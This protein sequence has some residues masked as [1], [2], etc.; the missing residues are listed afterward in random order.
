MLPREQEEDEIHT[1]MMDSKFGGEYR[2]GL[3]RVV[4]MMGIN[5]G[6]VYIN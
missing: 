6:G 2:G 1:T 4:N 5:C 3:V